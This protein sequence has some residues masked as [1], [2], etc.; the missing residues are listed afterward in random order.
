MK[1]LGGF[2][3]SDAA[4]SLSRCLEDAGIAALVVHANTHHKRKAGFEYLVFCALEEQLEDAVQLMRNPSH[5]VAHPVDVAA[6]H[7]YLASPSSLAIANRSLTKVLIGA[8]GVL[9]LLVAALVWRELS[10]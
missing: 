7:A 8:I 5:I 9:V 2:H 3:T 1:L 6:Y 4:Y 10:R